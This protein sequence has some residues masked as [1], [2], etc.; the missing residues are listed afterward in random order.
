MKDPNAMSRCDA[1]VESL[2]TPVNGW[3][4]HARAALMDAPP[5]A[6]IA[7]LVHGLVVSSSY[8][9]P[10]VKCLAAHYR[11]FAPD[12]PG[13]GRS[14]KPRKSLQI[15]ELADALAMWMDAVK[16]NQATIVGNSFGCQIGVEFAIRHPE[17]ANRLVLLGPTTDPRARTMVQQTIRWLLNGVQEPPSLGPVL[18]RDYIAAGIPRAVRT[19]RMSVNDEVDKKLPYVPVPTLVVRGAKDTIVPERW[20]DEAAS[21]LPLGERATIPG[22]GHTLNYNAPLESARVI[23]LF[24][25]GS[26][27]HTGKRGP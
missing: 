17:R 4:I 15:H 11:V 25:N 1:H 23:R 2:S 24:D 5:D 20:A 16:I 3:R 27:S 21:L 22:V 19:F 14:D 18:L 9:V 6:P 10:L 12:L 7:V 8:M 13:F 26:T